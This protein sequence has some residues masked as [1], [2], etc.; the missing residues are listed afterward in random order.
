MIRAS[1]GREGHKLVDELF[2]KTSGLTRCSRAH[3]MVMF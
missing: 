3:P 1:L 2:R